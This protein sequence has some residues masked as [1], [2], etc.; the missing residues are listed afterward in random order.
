MGQLLGRMELLRGYGRSS[1]RVPHQS[2]L[3]IIDFGDTLILVGLIAGWVFIWFQ[4]RHR[5]GD[6]AGGRGRALTNTISLRFDW[7]TL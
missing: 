3:P 7:A 6:D 4:K 1:H 2:Y 5:V